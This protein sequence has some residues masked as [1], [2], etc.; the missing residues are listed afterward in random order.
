MSL[1]RSGPQ[2]GILLAVAGAH[3]SG[4]PLNHEL[5]LRGARL[6]FSSRTARDYRMFV[7]DGPIPRPGVTRT[8]EPVDG[9]GIEVEVWR[10]PA[11]A[12]A[13]FLTT[14][15]PPL[16]IGPIDLIDGQQVLGFLCTADAADP[17][18]EI[19]AAGSWRNFQASTT[20]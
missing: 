6:A 18:R 17:D 14:I 8:L 11:A 4:E 5:V 20:A 7:V 19:T 10:L 15:A 2:D 13:D 16:G 12:L 1:S 3:L 9:P